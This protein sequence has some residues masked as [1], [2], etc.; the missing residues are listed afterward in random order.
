MAGSSQYDALLW[1]ASIRVDKTP[2]YNDKDEQEEDEE[3]KEE[4]K[5]T[6]YDRLI[7]QDL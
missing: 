6:K 4:K 5:N 2:V 7:C 3:E 1:S